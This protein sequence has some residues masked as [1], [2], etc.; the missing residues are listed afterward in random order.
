M[1]PTVRD[2]CAPNAAAVAVAEP[3]ATPQ[4]I[5]TKVPTGLNVFLWFLRLGALFLWGLGY[6][7]VMGMACAFGSVNGGCWMRMPWELRGEDLQFLVYGP[8]VIVA[9]VFI[10][11]W[12]IGRAFARPITDQNKLS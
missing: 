6:V 10:V 1:A 7:Q 8:G 4:V 12:L 11:T 3:R 5:Q 9:L 2:Q